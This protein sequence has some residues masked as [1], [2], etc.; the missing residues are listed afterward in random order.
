MYLA[1]GREGRE[2][3]RDPN[4]MQKDYAQT[5]IIGSNDVI[6]PS[7]RDAILDNFIPQPC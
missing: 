5:R 7:L 2:K 3:E 4:D 6:W 1:E